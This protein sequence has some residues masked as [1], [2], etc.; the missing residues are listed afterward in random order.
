MDADQQG[1]NVDRCAACGAPTTGTYRCLN[2]ERAAVAA[3]KPDP[4]AVATL[5]EPAMGG[6][7]P[8][9]LMSALITLGI[10]GRPGS[11]GRRVGLVVTVLA[12][13]FL[14]Y[15]LVAVVAHDVSGW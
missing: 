10:A 12:G 11:L 13:A 4:P 8:T 1:V 14:A 3:T 7:R 2:C 6:Y 9:D 15:V 5:D